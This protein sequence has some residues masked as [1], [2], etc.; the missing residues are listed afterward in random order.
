M[1][2][3]IVTGASGFVGANLARR[4]I[5][6]GHDTHLFV[7]SE[8]KAWRL[9]EV[10]GQAR[11]YA[12]DLADADA[13]HRTVATIRP[14]WVFHL[15]AHGAYSWQTSLDRMIATNVI[16]TINLV[17][18]CLR[19]GFEA[20]VNTGSSSEYG[21]KDHAPSEDEAVDPNS[22]YA[23]TKVS[24]TMYCRY[25]AQ[26]QGVRLPTLRLYS[27]Y[28]PWEDPNRLIPALLV[29]GL[30]GELPPLVN[31]Q[32]ARDYVY[33]ED[34]MDAYLLAAE[35]RVAEPGAVFNVGS[36]T[37]TSVQQAVTLCREILSIS[38]EPAWGS[39]PNRLWDT[40]VW[41]SDTRK[42]RRELGWIPQYSLQSG[43]LETVTWLRCHPEI[44][45]IY[46]A[47]QA[48]Q[49]TAAAKK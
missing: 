45:R 34:V 21:F 7:S 26:S 15:A 40:N 33:V 37:Q 35:Q 8:Q 2:R 36:G 47:R 48:D 22:D 4:L 24:A 49:S 42:I 10:Q 30:Q 1:K 43:L 27:V 29:R 18:A 3:A 44:E 19:A 32:T 39:M 46:R 9:D 11:M 23:V 25:V 41:V 14:D 5:R 12:L 17:Q 28:G 20:M 38:C 13:V 31:A 6:Q 16:G